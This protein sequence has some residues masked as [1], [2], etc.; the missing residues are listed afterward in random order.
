MALAYSL[1]MTRERGNLARR[2]IQQAD[3]VF[4]YSVP[5][6]APWQV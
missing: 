5:G 3:K 1:L 4:V 2:G 6:V